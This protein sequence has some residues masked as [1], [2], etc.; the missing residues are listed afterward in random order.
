MTILAPGHK[1]PSCG[2]PT[3]FAR[4]LCDDEPVPHAVWADTEKGVAQVDVAHR[5]TGNPKS[6]GGPY[7]DVTGNIT[8]ECPK[9]APPTQRVAARHLRVV[10]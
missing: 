2:C 4:V 1:H 7:E 3:L 10:K 6:F 9:H 8:L 5:K